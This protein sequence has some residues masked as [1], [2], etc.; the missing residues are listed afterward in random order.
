MKAGKH[1][2]S[3]RIQFEL[4][5]SSVMIDYDH[6]ATKQSIKRAAKAVLNHEK[7]VAKKK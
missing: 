7:E 5:I 4:Y 6:H 3:I 2:S 1:K